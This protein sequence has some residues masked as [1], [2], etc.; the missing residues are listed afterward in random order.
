MSIT[1]TSFGYRNGDV[2]SPATLTVDCRRL[3]NP[4]GQPQLRELTGRDT[5]VQTFIETDP[6]FPGV[7]REALKAAQ[8]GNHIAF[9]CFG[10]RHRSVAMVEIM[11]RALLVTGQ[12]V[13]IVHR[14]L[15]A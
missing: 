3:S 10:G 7:Y 2:A 8:N 1:L 4:H 11:A 6:K 14:D 9:G 13:T 12:S 15:A 5:L